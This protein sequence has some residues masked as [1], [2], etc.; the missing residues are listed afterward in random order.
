MYVYM[1]VLT[2]LFCYLI[3]LS[4]IFYLIII[5]N[6]RF[7]KNNYSATKY[8][9]IFKIIQEILKK[10]NNNLRILAHPTPRPCALY[11]YSCQL[12]HPHT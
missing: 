3:F 7:I 2:Y 11:I 9:V 5:H 12:Q 10:I 4:F 1:Y 6:L 8:W